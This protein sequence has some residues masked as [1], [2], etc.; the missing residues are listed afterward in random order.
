MPVEF[1][2]VEI[3]QDNDQL[4]EFLGHDEWP[5]HAQRVLAPGDVAAMDFSSPGVD[6]F[7]IIDHHETVGLVRLAGYP[8][9]HRIEANTRHDNAAMQRV[10]SGAGFTREGRLRETWPSDEGQWFDTVIYGI[11]RTDRTS[12]GSDGGAPGTSS[13]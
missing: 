2:R 1:R 10:L 8:A 7:W 4:V 5:F 3:P 9:L 6:S 12:L 11:L 13:G